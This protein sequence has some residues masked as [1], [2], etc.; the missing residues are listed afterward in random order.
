MEEVTVLELNV[1]EMIQFLRYLRGDVVV[2]VILDEKEGGDE[3]G[4][5]EEV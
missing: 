4:R 5:R 1:P 3:D 2:N